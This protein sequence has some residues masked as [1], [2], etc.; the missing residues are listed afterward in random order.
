M[1]E[2]W[3]SHQRQPSLN[4]PLEPLSPNALSPDRPGRCGARSSANRLLGWPRPQEP[5]Q[6][7]LHTTRLECPKQPNPQ[8]LSLSP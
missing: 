7:K 1:K 3:L 5:S 4:T 6:P 2:A 8:A